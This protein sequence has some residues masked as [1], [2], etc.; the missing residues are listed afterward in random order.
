M[1]SL[2][3][4]FLTTYSFGIPASLS[5]GEEGLMDLIYHWQGRD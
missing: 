3:P 1:Y 4:F 5:G 2:F